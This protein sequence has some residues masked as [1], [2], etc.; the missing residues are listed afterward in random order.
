MPLRRCAM[1]GFDKLAD[2]TRRLVAMCI[3]RHDG[4]GCRDRC[5]VHKIQSLNLGME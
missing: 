2:V 4:E 1:R 3:T 5:V